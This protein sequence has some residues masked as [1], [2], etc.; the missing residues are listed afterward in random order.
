DLELWSTDMSRC[1]RKIRPLAG[2]CVIFNT[3]ADSFHGHPRPLACPSGV[4]RKS[5]ALYYYSK[6]R[7]DREV[8]PTSITDWQELPEVPLPA[9]E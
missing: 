8:E 7:H 2:R 1:V 5:I 3:S 9:A 4:T 6:G